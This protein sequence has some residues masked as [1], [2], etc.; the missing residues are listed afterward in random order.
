MMSRLQHR[1]AET[2]TALD[3]LRTRHAL[4]NAFYLLMNDL[5]WYQRR[6][7]TAALKDIASVWIRLM[8]PFT[9]HVCEE[10]WEAAGNDGSVSLSEYPI[11]DLSCI[12]RDSERAEELVESTLG[13]IEEIVRVAGI[14]PGKITLFTAPDWKNVALQEALRKKKGGGLEMGALM[15]ELMKDSD[16]RKHAIPKYVQSLVKD[17]QRWSDEQVADC[18][19]SVN[20]TDVLAESAGFIGKEFNCAVEVVGAEYAGDD[21]DPQG[22]RRF[23]D[24]G[25]P[26]IYIEARQ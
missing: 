23:A 2:S 18:A 7:G 26:A 10:L 13:D 17:V 22:K 11:P 15:K 25:R 24:P 12:D 3:V 5:K 8:A 6:G 4:Q 21:I 9:P 16:I 19:R 1:I 20:E 14:K